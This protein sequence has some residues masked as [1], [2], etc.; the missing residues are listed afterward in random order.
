MS[1]DASTAMIALRAGGGGWRVAIWIELNPPHEI[2]HM[3]TAPVHH[4][5][6]A[7][8]AITASASRCSCS[9]YSPSGSSPSLF[10]VPL[11]ST[12]APAIP[13]LVRYE[14][15]S[16]FRPTESSLRYG[17][18]SSTTGTGI[19]SASGGRYRVA[20]SRT[21]SGNGMRASRLTVLTGPVGDGSVMG[22]SLSRGL[23]GDGRVRHRNG[24]AQQFDELR[25]PLFAQL[26]R[27]RVVAEQPRVELLGHDRILAAVHQPV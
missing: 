20:A 7:S 4:G 12:R 2:P 21:P 10:P 11:M 24:T 6:S 23:P 19:V 1:S 14:F 26:S 15:S 16:R 13:R 5:C 9:V 18:Y 25:H 3:P 22:C 17:K 8:H 27:L